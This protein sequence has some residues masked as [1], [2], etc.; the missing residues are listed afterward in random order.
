M[1]AFNMYMKGN[2]YPLQISDSVPMLTE[3]GMTNLLMS[4]GVNNTMWGPLI[5]KAYATFVGNYLT[6][7]TGGVS[8][9]TVRALTGFPG[10]MY[11]SIETQNLT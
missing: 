3:L 9:E 5:E 11:N 4:E 1:F 10:F 2:I 6:I 7:A 8:S